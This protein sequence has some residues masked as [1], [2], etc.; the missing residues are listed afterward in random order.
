MLTSGSPCSR[1]SSIGNDRADHA[2]ND[3][4]DQA[5]IFEFRIARMNF[6]VLGFEERLLPEL[7]ERQQAGPETV[8]HV[9][10][11]VSDRIRDICYLCFEARLLALEK[12][13]ADVPKPQA[14]GHC[15]LNNA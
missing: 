3:L 10:I 4:V 14:R 15:G 8:V 5:P 13:F 9:M 12:T 6:Q 2:T 11:V 1:T 7:I